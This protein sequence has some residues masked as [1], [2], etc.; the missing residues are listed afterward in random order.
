MSVTIG[1]ARI[2]RGSGRTPIRPMTCL[3]IGNLRLGYPAALRCLLLNPPIPRP[4]RRLS[5][6]VPPLGFANPRSY[7]SSPPFLLLCRSSLRT[8]QNPIHGIWCSRGQHGIL[9]FSAINL[10]HRGRIP[11]VSLRWN[12]L[13]LMAQRHTLGSRESNIFSITSCFNGAEV[14]LCG[15]VVCSPG[16]GLDILIFSYRANNPRATW[17]QF[18]EDVRRR[19]DPHY[20]VN[21]IELIAKLTQS[22]SMADYNR[23]FEKM[24]NK[25]SG[26]AESTLLPIYLSGLRSPLKNNVRFQHPTSVASAMAIAMEYDTSSERTNSANRHPW[27]GR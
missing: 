15:D 3:V 5:R 24:M 14:T 13:F 20:F 27:P 1:E 17:H 12:P 9:R 19:F 23:D 2:N 6:I 18:L 7:R 10:R 21:Y 8:P 16:Y 25:I 4:R 26:V 11:V 22:G